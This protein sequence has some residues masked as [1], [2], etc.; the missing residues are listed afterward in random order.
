[1]TVI[2]SK[3]FLTNQK[4]YFE[5]ALER[6]ILIKRGKNKF[7]FSNANQY[8]EILEPDGDFRRA[9]SADEFRERLVVVLDKIDKK[10][11]G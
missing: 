9:L 10:C 8:D 11:L 7:V 5:L 1:M 4:K 6:E 2:S 3:E